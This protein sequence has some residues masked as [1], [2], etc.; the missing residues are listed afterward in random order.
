MDYGLCIFVQPKEI[1]T[2]IKNVYIVL[3]KEKTFMYIREKVKSRQNILLRD[4]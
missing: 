3:T 4:I 1:F 2:N